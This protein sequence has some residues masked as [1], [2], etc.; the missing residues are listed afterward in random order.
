MNLRW[1]DWMRFAEGAPPEP[2]MM[3]DNCSECEPDTYLTSFYYDLSHHMWT[4]RWMHGGQG[5][6][7]WSAHPPP[8]VAWTQV[9]AV[10]ADPN[11]RELIGTW[12]H[13]D[14]GTQKP[15]EDYVYQYDLDPWSGLERTQQLNGK[16]ADA[17]KLRLCRGQD[18][19]AGMVRGQ[20]SPLC[21][22]IMNPHAEHRAANGSSAS[23]RG[24]SSAAGSHPVH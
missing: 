17:M 15:A 13:F 18:S 6:H 10:M 9:Y 4:A 20:D 5:L 1:L 2:A 22:Q 8:G 7:L 16:Q 21:E 19:V 3:Y 24:R 12:N 23:L 11:G 14:Y